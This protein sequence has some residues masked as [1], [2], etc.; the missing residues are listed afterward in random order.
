MDTLRTLVYSLCAF[1]FLLLI[2]ATF[3][4]LGCQPA[5]PTFYYAPAAEVSYNANK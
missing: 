4:M 5:K 1:A 2:G 3:L